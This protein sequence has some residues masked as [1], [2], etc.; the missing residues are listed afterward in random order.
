M[1]RTLSLLTH[2]P[3]FEPDGTTHRR[4]CECVRCDAGFRPTEEE[5]RVARLAVGRGAGARR[6][7]AG[8]RAAAGAAPGEAAGARAGARGGGSGGGGSRPRVAGRARPRR[9]GRA[10]G[11]A[12][13]P[14][15]GG[16]SARRGAGAGRTDR[17]GGCGGPS[18]D[19]TCDQRIKSP[20]LYQLSYRPRTGGEAYLSADPARNTSQAIVCIEID[21]RACGGAQIHGRRP[22]N[23]ETMSPPF[24]IGR[25]A[26]WRLAGTLF[27]AVLGGCATPR[28]LCPLGTELV[29]R[30]YSGGAETEWCRRPDG[31]R[32]G[33]ETRYYESGVEL[34]AGEYVDGDGERRLA[35]SLQR[36]PQL[37]RRSLGRRRAGLQD[38]RSRGRGP[39][40]RRAGRA[41]AD[42]VGDHQARPRSIRCSDARRASAPAPASWRS[43]RT[44]TRAWRA[45]T[46]S[47]GCARGSGASGTRTAG[48]SARSSTSRACASASRAP[49]TRTAA[50][51]RRVLSGGRARRSL[52]LVGRSGRERRRDDVPGGKEDVLRRG[53]PPPAPPAPLRSRPAAR[54]VDRRWYARAVKRSVTVQIAGV[55]YALKTDEDDRWVRVGGDVRRRRRSARRRRRRATPDTQAVAVLTALQIAE[56]LFH[57]AAAVGRTAEKDS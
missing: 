26:D 43:T 36:R 56:E 19:R 12:R 1:G 47:T 51:G 44:A 9:Q 39:V 24:P 14:A 2:L 22:H 34:A 53:E 30:V 8:A 32:Q 13:A 40:G 45:A 15:G 3:R 57:E 28:T 29:R 38:D 33:P 31:V 23:V 4:D 17:R 54:P 37:A 50:G 5:R 41:R 21:P 27:L 10:P 16:R 20:L 48:P 42:L 6:G 52:A 35:L 11:A 25:R 49:G 7:R 55:R 46:T 18:R